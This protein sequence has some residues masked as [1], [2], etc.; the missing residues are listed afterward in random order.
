MPFPHSPPVDPVVV[1]AVAAV[2]R[3]RARRPGVTLLLVLTL[4]PSQLGSGRAAEDPPAEPV[5]VVDRHPELE[6]LA[7]REEVWVD[8]R[9]RRVV[10]GGAVALDEGPIE[11]FACPQLTKEH[12]SVIAVKASARLVHAALLAI[13]LVP[14]KPVS[15]DPVYAAATGPAVRI[16]LRWRD[17]AGAAREADARTWVRNSRTGKVLEADWV[18]AGSSLWKDPDGQEHYQADAGDFV[19]VSNFP[20]ATLDLPIESSQSNEALLFEV[21]PERVPPVGTVVDLVLTAAAPVPAK[22]PGGSR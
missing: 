6:R 9:G 12:E 1:P 2:P 21:F 10:V 8:L 20:T 18:F 15:F 3:R 7:P 19:C 5:P 13:G 22:N 14:G 11:F 17:A 16:M 4:A